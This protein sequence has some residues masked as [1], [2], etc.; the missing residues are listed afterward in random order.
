MSRSA[1][2][3]LADQLR[4]WSD[5]ELA[6][7]L[8][9]RP[10]LASPAPQDS[11]QLASRAGTRASVLRAVDQL[12]VLEL[13][14]LDAAVALGGTTDAATLRARVNAEPSSVQAAVDRLRSLALLWGTEDDLRAL[15]IVADVVGTTVSGLGP[16]AATL[17]AGYGPNRVA[18]RAG[19][20]GLP[21]AGARHTDSA[22][23][24][25]RLS[26][27]GHV[28]R[29]V[30][31]VDEKA[32]AILDHLE[33]E[34]AD[35]T[36]ESAERAVSRKDV[37]GP[38]D[39]LLARGLLLARDGRHV[40]VPREVAICL[41]GGTTTRTAA[42]EAP[43]LAT[44]ERGQRL[45]DS[46]AAGAA[47][48]MVR[49]VELLLEHWGAAPP[50]A[51]RAGGLGV[52]DLRA[53]AELLHVE[54]SVAALYVELAHAA[55]LVAVGEDDDG[56]S[57]W[58]PTDAFD[59]WNAGSVAD[60]WVR[61]VLTWLD[62]PRLAGLVGG[63]A[64]GKPVNALSADLERAWLPEE[65]RRALDEIAALPEGQVLAA[66]T[67]I[68][69]L[70]DRLR[71]LRPRRPGQRALAVGWLVEESA[72]LGVTALGGLAAHGRALLSDD[73]PQHAAPQVLEPLLPQPVDHVL[74]Q[75]DLTAVAPGPLAHELA[76]NLATM[77]DIESRGGATVYRFTETSVRRAFDS[78]WSVAEVH[79]FI[80]T[81]SRTPVPQPLVYLV[82]DV[83]RKFGTVRVGAAESF[84]RS[85]DEIALAEL[86]HHP[87]AASL[88]LRRI[89]PTVVVSDV[90]VDVLLPRLRE[91]G[92]APVVE[93]ADG[94]VRLVRRDAQRART[95]RHRPALDPGTPSGPLDARAAARLTA[96][97]SATVTAIRA[98]DEARAHRPTGSG[99]R[100]ERTA[101][102]ST[103]ITLR[104]A[105]EARGT[106]W[107]G[108]VDNHGATIERMVDPVK[109]EGGW[110]SAYDHRSD[111][112]RSFAVHRITGAR[113]VIR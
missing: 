90:P 63:R 81:S 69:S 64:N 75:A 20:L 93:A 41:R 35:G 2:R 3:T 96:R 57:V 71:W 48:E 36:V 78:G 30:G 113:E 87:K 77:A 10:D 72:V 110:L 79:E 42:D 16:A 58:L 23:L 108:Y 28:E 44:S 17:L 43:P 100:L 61:L 4:G 80:E 83:S 38:V 106:V 85:D 15:S 88:R 70:V 105:A 82:D 33:R 50:S 94:T 29:L 65:R 55:G 21:P 11:A 37:L 95:P 109:V 111:E 9:A 73:D 34:G 56:D 53:T 26:Q 99:E 103:L 98:G 86:V 32:R 59:I 40:A 66:G 27:Q 102:M 60:R 45:V 49:H 46:A 62:T 5:A 51:L 84:L 13:T 22:A 25:A 24:A 31:E 12:T 47:F 39:Q 1:P 112:V 89:A 18:G 107:I 74:L 6:R 92:A 14:V 101:P 76:H 67:G 7:L 97:I 104:E 52:R 8:A 54:D 91:L 68:P 19:D